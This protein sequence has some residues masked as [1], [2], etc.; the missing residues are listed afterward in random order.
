MLDRVVAAIDVHVRAQGSNGGFRTPG[1]DGTGKWVGGPRRTPAADPL[2]GWGHT[3]LARAFAEVAGGMEKIGLLDVNIDDDDDPT[4]PNV[5]RRTSYLHMFKTSRSYLVSV[6]STYCPNQELGDA[7]G[8]WSANHA[9]GLLDK[10]AAWAE[11]TVLTQVVLPAIGLA[12]FSDAMWH[13]KNPK[14]PRPRGNWVTISPAGI[15][16]EAIGS[17][18]GGYSAAYSDILGDLDVWAAWAAGSGENRT[19]AALTA[20]LARM[21]PA[22]SHFRL[23]DNCVEP[24]AAGGNPGVVPYRCLK[25][26]AYIT[27]RNNLNPATKRTP[28]APHTALVLGD[29]TYRREIQ[30][31]LAL[32]GN[33]SLFDEPSSGPHWVSELLESVPLAESFDA[34][35]ALPD[36]TARLPQE[37]GHPDFAWADN[38]GRSVAAR[39]GDE[40]LFLTMQWRH[41]TTHGGSGF[42][43]LAGKPVTTNGICRVELTTPTID[44]LAT[45]ACGQSAGGSLTALHTLAFGPWL[46]AM[47]SD[48]YESRVWTVPAG[49]VGSRGTELVAGDTVDRLPATWTLAPNQT[50]VVYIT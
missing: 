4:T 48:L 13:A 16:L 10:T 32:A 44:R 29:P 18:A 28:I 15:S 17:L 39:V 40:R 7:K 24:A 20:V 9:A 2:E 14:Y 42:A 25:N 6:G 19:Y 23:L 41:D 21:A 11:E 26:T 5:T 47:N 34:L 46:V 27:W 1:A 22:F 49:Y 12:N 43:P 30:L 36:S 3:S 33:I 8:V 31:F 37:A 35:V 38:V 45:V 50:A